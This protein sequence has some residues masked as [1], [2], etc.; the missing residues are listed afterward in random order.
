MGM[1]MRPWNDDVHHMLK[2][3][4]FFKIWVAHTHT[5]WF[6][7]PTRFFLEN[8]CIYGSTAVC[9]TLAAFS[10]SWSF[11]TVGRTPWTGNEPVVRPLPP[12]R[13]T[14]IQNKCTQT[15]MRQVGFAFTIPVLERAK[16]ET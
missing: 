5:L 15:S 7:K 8:I 6:K 14:Q 10:V 9:W 2:W 13:T 11:Y 16:G 3:V 4:K 1:A 12:H